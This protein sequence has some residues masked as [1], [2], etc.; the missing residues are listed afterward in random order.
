[1]RTTLTFIALMALSFSAL[2]QK[3]TDQYIQ[4]S[5]VLMS[6]DSLMAIPYAHVVVRGT[7]K[8]TVSNYQGVFSFV[9][10]PGD[11][12]LFSAIGYK[13]ELFVIN[14]KLQD[15]RYSV[16]KLM[17]RD[18]IHLPETFVYPWPSPE[19]FREAFL[20]LN[21]PDDDLE[22]ARK[23]LERERLKEIGA[24]M[25]MDGNDN[26][27]YYMRQQAEKF[28]YQGQYPPQNLFSPIAWAKFIEAWK[29]GEYKRKRNR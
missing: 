17:T 28:S 18:T 11:S 20:N 6:S 1:M 13:T 21:I 22:R 8:G 24:S 26:T 15:D 3:T 12:V 9:A 19:H 5:G 16:L 23:N 14:P 4:F 10:E 29:N 25:A 27:D 7:N 2:A